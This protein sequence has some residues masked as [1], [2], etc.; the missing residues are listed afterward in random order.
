MSDKKSINKIITIVFVIVIILAVITVL[1]MYLPKNTEDEKH[2][3]TTEE[4]P[5]FFLIFNDIE[6][7]LTLSD[8]ESLETYS[9]SG[10]YIKEGA[11]PDNVIINGPYNFTG[12]NVSIILNQIE[13]LPEQY[14]IK[15]TAT[16]NWTTEYN[17]SEIN[18]LVSIYNESGNITNDGEVTML[19]AYKEEQEYINDTDVGPLRIV[20]VDS[21]SITS[22]RLWT[23]M[24][25][26]IEIIP[27]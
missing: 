17:M 19:L 26:S 9:A 16:D 15:V 18:G 20:F 13:N 22:S 14:I 10:T 8:I 2:L 23:K 25:Y 24:V 6:I 7:N 3:D 5:I 27:Q 4:S 1:Y 11:L 21:E 12:V